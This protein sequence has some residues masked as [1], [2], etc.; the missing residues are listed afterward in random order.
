MSGYFQFDL[1]NLD[2]R[3]WKLWLFYS[4]SAR[5]AVAIGWACSALKENNNWDWDPHSTVP[6]PR[7]KMEIV[8]V[9]G[10]SKT[11]FKIHWIMKDAEVLCENNSQ[12]SWSKI[13]FLQ[14]L[15]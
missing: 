7:A 4:A 13:N 11:C 2:F 3:I 12:I 5:E 6:L 15:L 9:V 10:I 8:Y 14:L 1:E